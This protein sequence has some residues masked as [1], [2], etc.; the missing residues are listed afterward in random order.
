MV[1]EVEAYS[2]P[3]AGIDAELGTQ[4]VFTVLLVATLI[5]ADIGKWRQRVEE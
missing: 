5:V 1:V 2:Q 4:V 3:L